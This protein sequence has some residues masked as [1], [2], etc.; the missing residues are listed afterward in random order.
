MKNIKNMRKSIRIVIKTSIY[1]DFF[2]FTFRKEQAHLLWSIQQKANKNTLGEK[3][4]HLQKERLLYE[5]V[6]KGR[7]FLPHISFRHATAL[8]GTESQIRT[9]GLSLNDGKLLNTR[10]YCNKTH[11]F[12]S[13]LTLCLLSGKGAMYPFVLLAK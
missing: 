6:K 10:K 7:I 12:Q 4:V 9:F 8:Y 2:L 13:N 3:S 11:I 1:D 5:T